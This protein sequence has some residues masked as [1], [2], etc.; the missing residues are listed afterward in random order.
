MFLKL[1]FKKLHT[2]TYSGYIKKIP[3]HIVCEIYFILHLV[4]EKVL[5]T[6]YRIK[7]K[8]INFL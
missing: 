7:H 2:T 5:D 1:V 3:Q 8:K 6:T 4:V